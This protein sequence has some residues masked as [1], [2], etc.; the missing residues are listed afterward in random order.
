MA[1]WN[2]PDQF[3]ILGHRGVPKFCPENTISSFKRAEALGTAGIELDVHVH[4]DKLVVIHDESVDRTT[5]GNGLLRE[6]NLEELR[7]LDAGGKQPI[8]FLT[9]VLDS[10]SSNT[11]VNIELKGN[12]TGQAVGRYLR[13][14]SEN[15]ERVL[16]SSFK[17][18]EL[19]NFVEICPDVKVGVL[20]RRVDP[21]S[22]QYAR[23]LSAFS[24]NVSDRGV[25]RSAVSSALRQGFYTMVYTVNTVRRAKTL[26][27]WGVLAI[28]TDDAAKLVEYQRLT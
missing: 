18:R 4:Q 12:D 1:S 23:E 17:I 5:N 6:F 7:T 28:F 25:S 15:K 27:G 9:E 2:I 13:R 16:V 19:R 21:Q 20:C 3:L 10:V 14:R 8:P 22:L 11:L 24:L 26:S